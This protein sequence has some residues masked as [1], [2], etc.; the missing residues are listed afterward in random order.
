V[1]GECL[2]SLTRAPVSVVDD[3]LARYLA[4]SPASLMPTYEARE[5]VELVGFFD[6]LLA[7]TPRRTYLD[8]V[9]SFLCQTARD[10]LYQYVIALLIAH[11]H[12]ISRRC[13]SPSRTRNSVCIGSRY[14]SQRSR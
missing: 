8:F 7:Q 3:L 5:D 14:C 10:E 9:A 11:P 1:M 12:R 13:C 2:R 4:Y 6:L